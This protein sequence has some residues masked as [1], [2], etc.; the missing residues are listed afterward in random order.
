MKKKKYIFDSSENDIIN[1]D[2]Q[3]VI[4]NNTG[5]D[6]EKVRK[7]AMET[8]RNER[9]TKKMSKK[10]VL[11]VVGIA[12]AIAVVSTVTVSAAIG[13]F[14]PVFAEIIAGQPV[15]GIFPGKDVSVKSDDVDIDFVGL[16]GDDKFV[17]AVYD[18]TPKNGSSFVESTDDC[19]F[20]GTNADVS[21]SES[22]WKQLFGN[23]SY[24]SSNGVS[25]ELVSE[26][27]I[28]AFASVSDSRGYLKGERMTIS[29]ANTTLF[30]VEKEL[31]QYNDIE[32]LNKY[33]EDNKDELDALEKT[34]G[35]DEIL[36][37]MINDKKYV[38][39]KTLA[40]PC[41]YEL[42]V[43]LDY[44][45]TT[46]TFDDSV[47]KEFDLFNSKFRITQLSATSFSLSISAETD[48]YKSI[49]NNNIDIVV[50]KKDGTKFKAILSTS[51]SEGKDGEYGNFTWE[52]AFADSEPYTKIIVLDPADIASITI[53]GT[54]IV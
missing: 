14:N 22:I 47:G 10:K 19:Y 2:E 35:E 43:T 16:C 8:I 21:V 9:G 15:D 54:N 26:N 36:F 31:F 11:S 29:D 38:V 5:I 27:K 1:I 7:S 52:L 34:L 3:T 53:N 4:N 32:E 13:G 20:Y 41:S 18:I 50:E 40:L 33:L 25:Y 46:R 39:A 48:D 42:S 24:G 51:V 30:K 44:K 23:R 37:P 45:T 12:A 6:A 28:R 49:D 17:M